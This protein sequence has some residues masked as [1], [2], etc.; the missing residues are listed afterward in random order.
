MLII[1]LTGGVASGKNFVASHFQKSKIPVFDAD[2]EVHEL[3]TSNAEIMNQISIHFPEAIID[4]KINRKILG[5]KVFD[6]KEGLNLLEN[7]I[8]PKLEQKEDAFL[9]KCRS[10]RQKI[11]ILNVPLLFE[12]KGYK[13]CHKVISIIIPP[14]I[15]LRRFKD[16]FKNTNFNDQDLNSKFLKITQ[17]QLNNLARKKLA[18]FTI[19]NGLDKRF[20]VKQINAI[21][22]SLKIA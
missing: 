10:N 3:L 19:Y 5:D 15:Q 17:N 2:E 12:K 7:I 13:K 16:R 4:N 11:A 14:K 1:G 6:N 18:D 20:C 8:Y 9:K 21:K 22:S